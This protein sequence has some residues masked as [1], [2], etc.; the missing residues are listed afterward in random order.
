MEPCGIW[1][2]TTWASCHL[3]RALGSMPG[4]QER[5]S[6][7]S[8]A[9]CSLL[10]GA[11]RESIPPCSAQDVPRVFQDSGSSDGWLGSYC[12]NLHTSVSGLGQL[13]SPSFFSPNGKG[14]GCGERGSDINSYQGD[15]GGGNVLSFPQSIQKGGCYPSRRGSWEATVSVPLELPD[16]AEFTS[17]WG[18]RQ[19][20]VPE[21]SERTSGVS[22]PKPTTPPH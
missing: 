20:E 4:Y 15:W 19:A 16:V 13:C 5:G 11:G 8:C 7:R 21:D 6:L 14:G 10:H 9:G 3:H 1:A 17:S 2:P 12:C 22:G 18:Q